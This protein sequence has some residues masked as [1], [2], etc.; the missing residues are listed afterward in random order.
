MNL[1]IL[2]GNGLSAISQKLSDIK[3]NFDPLEIQTLSGKEW[4]FEGVVIEL[5]TPQLFSDKRLVVL[6][7]FDP[8][9]GGQMGLDKLPDDPDLTVVLKISKILTQNSVILKQ[10]AALKAQIFQFSEKDETSIFPFLDNL[11]EKR[12]Q[13]FLDLEKYLGEWG[14][15]YVLTMIFYLLRRL[16]M[17]PKKLPEF[18]IRK[19]ERQKKN[20]SLEEIKNLY[21]QTLETD[22]KIKSGLLEEKLGIT[23]LVNKILSPN[24]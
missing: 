24:T 17:K 23:L 9:A 4:D 11:A 20:F 3:K 12:T 13:A 7:D 14:G 16:I 6:E 21:K 2:H 5:S 1:I 18:V 10:A 8:P 15:Q 19:I 22:F